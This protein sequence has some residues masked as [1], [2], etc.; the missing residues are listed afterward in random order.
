MSGRS[1]AETSARRWNLVWF[2]HQR[3]QT[4]SQIATAL[5]VDEKLV[6]YYLAKGC[7]PE[8]AERRRNQSRNQP[9]RS[10]GSSSALVPDSNVIQIRRQA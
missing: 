3:G 7:P 9:V 1:N 5:S 8:I 6:R 2:K 10:S 4:N